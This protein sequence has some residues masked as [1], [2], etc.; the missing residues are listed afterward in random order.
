MF[1]AGNSLG[2]GSQ[3][4]T[5]IAA[6]HSRFEALEP[7]AETS[8][9]LIRQIDQLFKLAEKAYREGGGKRGKASPIKALE[10]ARSE[11]VESLKQVQRVLHATTTAEVAQMV[12]GETPPGDVESSNT[13]SQISQ[14]AEQEQ[15]GSFFPVGIFIDNASG[16][17]PAEGQR[18][19][20]F[21][22]SLSAPTQ[23]PVTVQFATH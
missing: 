23:L 1:C 22:V 14:R 9:D 15:A 2:S 19:L 8:R 13:V 6:L 20:A 3:S 18:D 21:V 5:D 17:E 16:E 12:S 11:A 10:E 7:M 4:E